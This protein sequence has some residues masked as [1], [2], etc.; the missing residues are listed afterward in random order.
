MQCN[1]EFFFFS[2]CCY[3]KKGTHSNPEFLCKALI[4]MSN[5]VG[6]HEMYMV[7]KKIL[8]VVVLD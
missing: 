2:I 3:K 4:F 6:F 8:V 1:P 7:V 5:L